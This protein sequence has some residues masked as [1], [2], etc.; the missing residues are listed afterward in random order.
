[1]HGG[2]MHIAGD[3]LHREG[4][5][6]WKTPHE[7]SRHWSSPA[8]FTIHPAHLHFWSRLHG[9]TTMLGD[10]KVFHMNFCRKRIEKPVL[11]QTNERSDEYVH[12]KVAI[13][14]VSWLCVYL[15]SSFLNVSISH[16]VSPE[17]EK[18][19]IRSIYK[20]I[21]LYSYRLKLSSWNLVRIK[22]V[23]FY[24]EFFV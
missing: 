12:K 11:I 18:K 24:Y 19:R 8:S 17:Y 5:E 7:S 23:F 15:T 1:M 20:K 6:K 4:N 9:W 21:L 14:L 22:R 13:L 2:H 3:L 16:H 10:R